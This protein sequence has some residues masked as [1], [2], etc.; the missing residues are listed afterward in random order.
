MTHDPA[1]VAVLSG[2]VY[3]AES[4]ALAIMRDTAYKAVAATSPDA[5]MLAQ[6]PLILIDL[7]GPLQP[8]LDLI[9][10]IISIN[11]QAK[12]ILLGVVESEENVVG[13]AEAGASGY[14]PQ[15]ASL[16]DLTSVIQSVQNGEFSC[17]PSMTYALFSHLSHLSQKKRAD[18]FPAAAL[19]IRQREVLELL[20]LNL[21][22]KEI[23][24]RLCLSEHTVKNHVHHILK[25][26]GVRGRNQAN[27]AATVS[28][29]SSVAG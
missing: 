24:V 2:S 27:G 28:L 22:N 5:E 16:Q 25:K 9:D 18:D 26:L 8:S 21:S 6:F 1:S 17:A 15:S 13:L 20:S 14:I 4:L 12:I 23:A 11:P 10:R 3:R 19:S 7:D 29:K